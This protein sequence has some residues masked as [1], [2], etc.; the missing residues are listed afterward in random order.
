MII[1]LSS[2]PKSGNT[3]IRSFLSAYYFT[4]DGQFDFNLLKYIEQFPDKQFFNGFVETKESASKK[5][6]PLQKEIVKSKKIKFLKTHSA[7][8]S[9]DKNPF[10][11]PETTL[12]GI[13]IVRDPRNVVSSLM[14][15]FSLKREEALAMLLD[16]NRAIKS[17]DNNYAT[18][19]FLSSWSNH[20]KSWSNIRSFKTI[21][22][23][24][25]DLE[26]NSENIF[27]NLIQ[28]VNKLLNNNQGIDYQKFSKALETT[29]FNFLKKKEQEKGFKEAIF[30]EEKDEKIPFF[31]LGFRNHWKDNLNK[32]IIR[33][34]ESK[35]KNEMKELKYL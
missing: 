19:T 33:E 7:Y 35:F 1:W 12:G 22:I 34:I 30:S 25:E 15:H 14:N 24:Y 26:K 16:E 32:E 17:R 18:F 6:L 13:Y 2:Y 28:F 21:L 27:K 29:K 23:R 11:T 3:Y 10:T 4:N 5:W 31:N 20:F 9:Y 8:G